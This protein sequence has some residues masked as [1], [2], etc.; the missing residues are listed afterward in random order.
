M[1]PTLETVDVPGHSDKKPE[2]L[3]ADKAYDSNK[4]RQDVED[5]GIEPIFPARKN[6]TKATHQDGRRLRRYRNRWTVERTNAW[7]QNF[8]RLVVRY[9]RRSDIFRALIHMAFAL[10]IL[11]KLVPS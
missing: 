2:N 7:L 4:A 1:I 10:I 11:K 5:R 9:E 3:I 6:N 8:R